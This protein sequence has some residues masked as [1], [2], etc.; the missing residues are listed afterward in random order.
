MDNRFPPPTDTLLNAVCLLMQAVCEAAKLA[1]ENND[2]AGLR[3]A[4]TQYRY[5]DQVCE[6]M[7]ERQRG[8]TV[9]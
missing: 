1:E 9:H 7:L 8:A 6:A 3:V 2:H 5:L 4:R